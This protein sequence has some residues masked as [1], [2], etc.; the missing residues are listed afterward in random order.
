MSDPGTFDPLV[1]LVVKFRTDVLLAAV[2][3]RTTTVVS[4]PPRVARLS[5]LGRTDLLFYWF[6]YL[7][8]IINYV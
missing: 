3:F 7:Q 1:G 4:I 2:L 5:A 6:F 8:L